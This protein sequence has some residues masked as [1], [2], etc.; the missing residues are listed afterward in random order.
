M[1]LQQTCCM[2]LARGRGACLLTAAASGDPPMMRRAIIYL[3]I[4]CSLGCSFPSS[5]KSKTE[6]HVN[7]K[8][9]SEGG[10]IVEVG[11]AKTSKAEGPVNMTVTL[12]N[13]GQATAWCGDRGDIVDC[14]AEIRDAKDNV[15]ARTVHGDNVFGDGQRVAQYANVRLEPGTSKSWPPESWPPYDLSKCFKF[16]PG[17][18]ALS[19]TVEFNSNETGPEK[20]F[21]I[22]VEKIPFTIE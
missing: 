16:K 1:N 22:T 6:D 17:D 3:V 4:A 11:I 12:I 19:L 8:K 2:A 9:A 15:V 18:H 5:T 13:N 14:H 21:S 10:V 7:T 20:P